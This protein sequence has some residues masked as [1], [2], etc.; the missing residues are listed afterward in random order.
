MDVT[1]AIISSSTVE[2]IIR[3]ILPASF[4]DSKLATL[5]YAGISGDTGNFRWNFTAKTLKLASLLLE[6]GAKYLEVIEKSFSKGR[7]YIMKC[8][9][10]QSKTVFL[11]K[12]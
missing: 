10:L 11:T 9:S 6:K 8:L 5:A 3:E 7:R 1:A 2:I 4:L 12:I